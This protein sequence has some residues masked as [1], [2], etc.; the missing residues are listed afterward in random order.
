MAEGL[1]AAHEK[2][3]VHR[4]IKPAN[5]WLETRRPDEPA[6]RIKLLDFGVARPLAVHEHLT[7]GGQIIGTPVY[8]SP[9]QACG[10]PVDER[11]DL[12]SLGSIMY[13]MLAGK[14]P[15]ERPSYLH[16]LKA[17]VEEQPA[18]LSN[19]MPGISPEVERLVKRLLEKD[20]TA[21]PAST[22]SGRRDSSPGAEL[23]EQRNG[24][25]TDFVSDDAARRLSSRL[26]W[27]VWSGVLAIL[28]AA[29]IGLLSQYHRVLELRNQ[30]AAADAVVAS[31]SSDTVAAVPLV[32][33]RVT[34]AIDHR[35]EA[36]TLGSSSAENNVTVGGRGKSAAVAVG[37]AD[38]QTL[39]DAA[40]APP[41]IY[42]R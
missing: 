36:G 17:V 14:S 39:P 31:V 13:A 11:S 15:F 23:Y 3:L 35:P 26:N 10:M 9:E 6:R 30:D 22:T 21:R 29:G 7:M 19:V 1:A 33:S 34:P 24:S 5:V 16:V 38:P 25:T 37:D 18:A 41:T 27:G 2:Q 40:A 32:T 28:A 4:D 12:F 8:M 42:R 20:A